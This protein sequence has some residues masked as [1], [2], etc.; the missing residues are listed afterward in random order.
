MK[1]AIVCNNKGI[2]IQSM[3]SGLPR[4]TS[5][6]NEKSRIRVTNRMLMPVIIRIQASAP[7]RKRTAGQIRA[8][9]AGPDAIDTR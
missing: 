1:I 3:S 6:L 8:R 5:P 2:A 4:I 9:H 7:V